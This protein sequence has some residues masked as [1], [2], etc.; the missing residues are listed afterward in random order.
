MAR[1]EVSEVSR[2]ACV[3]SGTIGGGWAALF[4]ANGLEVIATDPAPDAESRLRDDVA[5]AW[6]R[7]VHDLEIP[8]SLPASCS[9]R[10]S[11]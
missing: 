11:W 9:V 8:S 5:R 1:V 2:V 4:L 10:S 6:T 3:G 7:L